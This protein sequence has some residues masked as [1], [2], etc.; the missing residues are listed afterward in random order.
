MFVRLV[1]KRRMEGESTAPLDI[2][3][4]CVDTLDLNALPWP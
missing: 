4:L 2:D 1:A 3:T